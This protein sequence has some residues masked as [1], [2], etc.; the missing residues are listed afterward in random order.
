M[1]NWTYFKRT[2][3][4]SRQKG[5]CTRSQFVLIKTHANNS[6][7]VHIP[8]RWIFILNV[9]DPN[10]S[11]DSPSRSSKSIDSRGVWSCLDATTRA[12]SPA[13]TPSCTFLKLPSSKSAILA[14]TASLSSL[15]RDGGDGLYTLVRRSSVSPT[16]SEIVEREVPNNAG[17]ISADTSGTPCRSSSTT[18]LNGRG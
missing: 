7:L 10:K 5:Y 2:P 9:E 15:S 8:V 11:S 18:E 13:T 3:N 1:G 14:P 17:A 6:W 4:D 12:T 16:I